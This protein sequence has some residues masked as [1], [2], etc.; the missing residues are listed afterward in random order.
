MKR[1]ILNSIYLSGALFVFLLSLNINLIQS[2]CEDCSSRLKEISIEETCCISLE[3]ISCCDIEEACCSNTD[4]SSCN[5]KTNNIHFDFETLVVYSIND[6]QPK[7]ID[8]FHD[9][10][11]SNNIL[12]SNI[13][14]ATKSPPPSYLL[15]KPILSKIQVFLI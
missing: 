3:N 14:F 7:L 12:Y 8:L 6:F 5:P 4:A 10:I 11:Q 15:A 9:L 2:C 1:K 13:F